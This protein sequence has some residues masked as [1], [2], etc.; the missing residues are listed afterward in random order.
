MAFAQAYR[1]LED[2]FR[3]MVGKDEICHGIE[4]VFLPNAAPAGQVDYVLVG[5]EP[6]LSGMN[7]ETAKK[8]IARGKFKNWGACPQESTLV[9][10]SRLWSRGLK[11]FPV[12]TLHGPGLVAPS[13]A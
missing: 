12:V 2:K 5:M 3:W 10:Q 11:A 8:K 4:S 1:E 9:L 7:F 6:G 13:P